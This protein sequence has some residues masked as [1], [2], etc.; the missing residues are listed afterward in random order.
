[1]K[2]RNSF[3]LLLVGLVVVTAGSALAADKYPNRGDY[4]DVPTIETSDLFDGLQDDSIVVVDVRSKLEYDVI[5]VTGAAHAPVSKQTF[6]AA[7]TE[8]AK[9]N[10]GKTLVFYCNGTTCLK[11][12]KATEKAMYA[13]LTSV[14]AYDAGIPEWANTWP[15]ETLLLGEQIVDPAQQLISKAAF[16][17]K[18]LAWE[19]FQADGAKSG[20]M[21]IDVRDFIQKSGEL[22]GLESARGIPL[23]T[24]I[25]NFVAKQVNQDKTLLIF[26]QVGKQIKWL[27]YYLE[28]YGYTDYYFLGGGATNVLK[29]QEYRS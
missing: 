1:M 12:Y 16:K 28:K 2:I 4:P 25:P 20:V 26:D 13:G 5:H 21:V 27:Q 29:R 10:P 18:C 9:Q 7:V 3:L 19:V 15:A 22:P 17:E 6:D 11:S 8:L 14:A 23:D 24:F